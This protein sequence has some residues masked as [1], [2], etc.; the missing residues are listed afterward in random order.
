VKAGGKHSNRLAEI[1][2]YIGNRREMEDRKSVP[3]DPP[4]EQ[5]ELPLLTGSQT[6]QS[7]PIGDLNRITSFWFLYNPK[8][9]QADC[10]VCYMLHAGFL[11]GL[12][13][14]PE[15]GGDMFLRNVG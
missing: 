1:S 2:D 8:F 5:N 7:E 13:F 3:V 12:F 14:D 15:D 6:Q 9:W 10:S 11:L 4:V